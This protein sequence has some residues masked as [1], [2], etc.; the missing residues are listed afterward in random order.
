MQ[1]SKEKWHPE[2]AR[3]TLAYSVLSAILGVF[4]LSIITDFFSHYNMLDDFVSRELFEICHTG[5]LPIVTLILEAQT[6]NDVQNLARGNAK[7]T[8]MSAHYWCC[9]SVVISAR[10]HASFAI[11]ACRVC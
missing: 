10:L 7:D 2:K 5:L 4:I 8:V 3:M 6:P 9:C 11:S 1:I